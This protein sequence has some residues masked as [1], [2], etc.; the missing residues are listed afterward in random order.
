M[1]VPDDEGMLLLTLQSLSFHRLPA[2]LCHQGE[3]MLTI[4]TERCRAWLAAIS[5]AN[6]TEV[7]YVTVLKP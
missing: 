7:N 3:Q 1:N 4:S 5:R 2:I 6:L